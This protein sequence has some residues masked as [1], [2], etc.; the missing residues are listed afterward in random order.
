MQRIENVEE[1]YEQEPDHNEDIVGSEHNSP[2]SLFYLVNKAQN[3][4]DQ[5]KNKSRESQHWKQ[6][7][8]LDKI[9]T[10]QS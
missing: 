2:R 4:T 3:M 7:G 6:K 10:D 5:N 9:K 1:Y 8:C